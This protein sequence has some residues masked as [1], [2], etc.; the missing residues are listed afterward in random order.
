MPV[1]PLVGSRIVHPG[2]QAAVAFSGLDHREADP[3]LHRA[4]GVEGFH[5]PRTV[6]GIPR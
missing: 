1:F 2:Q 5:L 4:G 3:I 6:A